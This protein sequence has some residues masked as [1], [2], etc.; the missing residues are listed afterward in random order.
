MYMFDTLFCMKKQS[1]GL[2]PFSIRP[3]VLS[4]LFDN[5]HDLVFSWYDVVT[6]FVFVSVSKKSL[7]AKERTTTSTCTEVVSHSSNDSAYLSHR[8]MT[9]AVQFFQRKDML[10]LHYKIQLV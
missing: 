9:L 3:M 7:N 5:M 10:P 4:M 1:S 2:L 8:S 6:C